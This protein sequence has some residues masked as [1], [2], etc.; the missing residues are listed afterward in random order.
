[1]ILSRAGLGKTRPLKP[2]EADPAHIERNLE[3][4]AVHYIIHLN[5]VDVEAVPDIGGSGARSAGLWH[6]HLA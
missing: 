4:S 6:F 3:F 5:Y 2:A 1:M